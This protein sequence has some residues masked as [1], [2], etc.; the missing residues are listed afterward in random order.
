MSLSIA[1]I[2]GIVG[3]ICFLGGINILLKGAGYF[4]PE[5]TPP[6][7]VLDNVVRFLAGIYFG[8][9]FL[10]AWA[11]IHVNEINELVYL[12]GIVVCFSG[13]GRL[14]SRIKMGPGGTYLFGVMCLEII[15]G[16]ALI[17]L[18]YFR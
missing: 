11:T 17:L 12:L 15:L 6:Q 3:A 9:S 7:I 2:L 14:Y 5:G 16:I 18:Q 1:I 13:L 4:L 8:M 10:L